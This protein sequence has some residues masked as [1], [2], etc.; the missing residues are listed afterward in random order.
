LTYLRSARENDSQPLNTDLSPNLTPQ[1]LTYL[2]SA[3]AND[4]CQNAL[5]L[6]LTRSSASVRARRPYPVYV[7]EY[8]CLYACSFEY[9]C[10]Y[11][12][13]DIHTHTLSLSLS[14]SVCLS[15]SLSLTHSRMLTHIDTYTRTAHPLTHTH[16]LTLSLS[17][18]HTPAD[19]DTHTDTHIPGRAGS[20]CDASLPF[21][22]VSCWS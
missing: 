13:M 2:R 22:F 14:L 10:L 16:S 1:P 6:P 3:R 12:C 21:E 5:I 15:L 18:I 19:K 11:A 9:V 17:L 8:V 4:S 20:F 7:F